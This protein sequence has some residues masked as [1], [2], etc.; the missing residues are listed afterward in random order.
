MNLKQLW[1]FDY[2]NYLRFVKI[3]G[4]SH[5]S[6]VINVYGFVSLFFRRYIICIVHIE[7]DYEVY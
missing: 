4:S 3:L 6:L 2:N 7:F 1:I 5:V